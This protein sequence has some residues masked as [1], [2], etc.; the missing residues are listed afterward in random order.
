[1]STLKHMTDKED[2][3]EEQSIASIAGETLNEL[4]LTNPKID[5]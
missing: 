4:E 5:I 1:M 2:R 3:S